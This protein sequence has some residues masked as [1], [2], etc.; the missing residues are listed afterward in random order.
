MTIVQAGPQPLSPPVFRFAPSPNGYLH[1]GHAYSALLNQ[2]MARESGGRLLLR[3]EDID[4]TRC[5]PE[6]EQAIYEDLE[7]LGLE[8][9][10]PVRRQS[11]HF[12]D[13]ALALGKLIKA[14]LVYQSYLTRAE[15][16]KL[17]TNTDV[18]PSGALLHPLTER[19]LD[20][21]ITTERQFARVP[22][23]W[24]LNMDKALAVAPIAM[25]WIECGSGQLEI[26]KADPAA[27]GD[28]VVAR[29]ETPT[30]Y[31]LSVVIDDALQGVTDVVRGMDLYAQTSIH[32]LLHELL[33]LPTP[34]YF[35]HKLISGNDG[36][37]LA[38]SASS[39]PLRE[40]RNQGITANEIRQN[41]GF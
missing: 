26:C 23:A 8:W 15:V 31:H 3:I 35:H 30:S 33:D 2:R 4:L 20:W 17:A 12:D 21:S 34:R 36:G 5:R 41:L 9:E 38:K 32:R 37:K 24:R 25:N 13:Y 40:L 27:W 10:T 11:E 22:S 19:D 18:D 28:V 1:L 14:G 29:K 6:Y 16:A 7:W 39:L